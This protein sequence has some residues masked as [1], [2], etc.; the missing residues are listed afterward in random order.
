MCNS[1]DNPIYLHPREEN[2]HEIATVEGPAAFLD[3]L[4]P[5]YGPDHR[6]GTERECHYYQVR[7]K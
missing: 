2:L 7:S 6:T 5:P 4:S 1:A 3:I